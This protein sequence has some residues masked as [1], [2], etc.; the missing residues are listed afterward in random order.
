MFFLKKSTFVTLKTGRGRK[1]LILS[2]S[3]TPAKYEKASLKCPGNT[4]P[5]T[6]RQIRTDGVSGKFSFRG[7]FYVTRER[8]LRV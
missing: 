1:H 6:G 2:D 7:Y 5:S 4:R 8:L 3:E